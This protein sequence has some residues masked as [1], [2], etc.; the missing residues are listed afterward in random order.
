MEHDD[1]C[2][3]LGG[4][5]DRFSYLR[6]TVGG[7]ADDEERAD[8]LARNFVNENDPGDPEDYAQTICALVISEKSFHQVGFSLF[9]EKIRS[10]QR[11][12]DWPEA[13]VWVL[14]SNGAF[15]LC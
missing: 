2:L 12:L 3:E 15:E 11:E 7:N 6:D 4:L 13:V 8:C 9:V 10:A 14:R 1:L 5:G